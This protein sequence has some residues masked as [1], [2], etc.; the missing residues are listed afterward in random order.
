M[1]GNIGMKSQNMEVK[2]EAKVNYATEKRGYNQMKVRLR[3][4]VCSISSGK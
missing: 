3:S 2:A 1:Q 4:Q